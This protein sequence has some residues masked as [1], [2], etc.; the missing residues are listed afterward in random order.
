MSYVVIYSV[1]TIEIVSKDEDVVCVCA[2]A[3]IRASRSSCMLEAMAV[4]K[5][6]P[7]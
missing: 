3:L 5:S 4:L 7:I 2:L 1:D 6:F